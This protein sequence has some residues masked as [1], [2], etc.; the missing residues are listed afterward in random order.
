MIRT[1]ALAHS[2]RRIGILT[3]CLAALTGLAGCPRVTV[4]NLTV[5][6]LT[7][8]SQASASAALSSAGLVPGTITSACSD[9]VPA[10]NVIRQNPAADAPVARGTAVNLVISTGPCSGTTSCEPSAIV[11]FADENLAGRSAEPWGCLTTPRLPVLTCS[12]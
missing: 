3:C 8:Q 9:T 7:G 11:Y 6:D 12:R 2:L 10:G 5:P 1:A 4:P